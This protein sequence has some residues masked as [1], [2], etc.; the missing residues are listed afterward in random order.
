MSKRDQR[1]FL[2]FALYILKV[3]YSPHDYYQKALNLFSISY[4]RQAANLNCLRK[5]LVN[6]VNFLTSHSCKHIIGVILLTERKPNRHI[7]I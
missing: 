1:K 4:R 5:L 6:E 2:R 7:E 3:V